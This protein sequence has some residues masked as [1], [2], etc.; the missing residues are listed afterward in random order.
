V[1]AYASLVRYGDPL[2]VSTVATKALAEGYQDI[3]LHEIAYEPIA[4]ARRAVAN[5][6][7]LTTAVNCTWSLAETEAMLPKMKA[8]NLYWVEEP[9]WPPEDFDTLARLEEQFGVAL[10]AGENACTAFQFQGL[11]PAVTFV[12]PSVTK[13][14]GILEFMKVV[15]AARLVGKQVMPHSPYFGPGWWATLQL[16]AHA[17]EIELIEYL[18]IVSEGEV[19]KDIPLPKK[20][21]IQI[22]D[23]P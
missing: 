4:A 23:T 20:G 18:Y 7:R 19:G 3:K 11:V 9:I 6:A 12:Q 15:D 16:A 22:P 2:V 10:A 8:L 14:G 5:H 13:V 21:T 1:P 17:P